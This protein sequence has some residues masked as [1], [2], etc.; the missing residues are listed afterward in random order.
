M[1]YTVSQLAKLSGVSKRT[2]RYY[3][4][5]DLLKPARIESNGYRIYQEAQVNQL[6]QILFYR[7]LDVSLEEIKNILNSPDFDIQKALESHLFLLQERKKQIE[8]LIEN[9]R[10][11]MRARKGEMTMK[12]SEKFEGMKREKLEENEK[13]YGKEIREKYGEEIVNASNI[14]F[15]QMSEEEWN[16]SEELSNTIKEKLKEAVKK[17][18]PASELAQEVCRLHQKW[19]CMFWKE[20]TYSKEAHQNLVQMYVEDERFRSYYESIAQGA[21]QFLRDAIVIYCKN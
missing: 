8:S 13:K 21:A 7:Q 16:T 20:G 9:V 11:T 12:D 4:E 15:S 6:Q 17:K 5:I 18:N 2:L 3:D 19:I 1:E 14:K 10:K